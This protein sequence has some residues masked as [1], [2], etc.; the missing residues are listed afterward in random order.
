MPTSRARSASPALV[1]A[2]VSHLT[3]SA[4]TA[5]QDRP[6][7]R[8]TSREGRLT[9]ENGVVEMGLAPGGALVHLAR[10]GGPNLVRGGGSAKGP[11]GQALASGPSNIIPGA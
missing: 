9:L 6:P 4:A 3:W 5:A 8:L 7:V 1:A 11:Y 2:L 10:K